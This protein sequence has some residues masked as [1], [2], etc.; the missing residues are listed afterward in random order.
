MTAKLPKYR[1]LGRIF[2]SA[3]GPV[4]ARI[5]EADE[6]FDHEGPPNNAFLPLNY[7]ARVAKLKSIGSH[8][9]ENP[10]PGQHR[11]LATSL[12]WAGG[13]TAEADTYIENWIARETQEETT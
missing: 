7:A 6:V 8:W 9:R 13:T 11:R 2:L 4:A 5:I 3:D 10:H 1:A 12:G